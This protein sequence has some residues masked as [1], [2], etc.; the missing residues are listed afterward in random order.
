MEAPQEADCAYAVDERARVVSRARGLNSILCHSNREASQEQ[1]RDVQ[2]N[3]GIKD[4]RV[5]MVN[6]T[7]VLI[8]FVCGKRAIK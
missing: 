2:Q 1:E 8:E 3:R 4:V 5:Q 7:L 6:L